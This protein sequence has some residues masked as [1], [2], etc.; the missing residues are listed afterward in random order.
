MNARFRYFSLS[1]CAIYLAVLITATTIIRYNL[2]LGIFG[3][4]YY[5]GAIG[6]MLGIY[7]G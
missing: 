4:L 1:G 3:L 2:K 5:I 7:S 6:V